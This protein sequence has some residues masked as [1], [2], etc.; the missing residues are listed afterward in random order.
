MYSTEC[1]HDNHDTG[2]R[3]LSDETKAIVKKLFDEGVQKPN[4]II[5]AM[6]KRNFMAPPKAKLVPFLKQL[7]KKVQ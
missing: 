6:R 2:Q 7:R 4:G 1:E 3:G 5:Y